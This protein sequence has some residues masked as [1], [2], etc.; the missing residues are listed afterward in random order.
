[1]FTQIW[2]RLTYIAYKRKQKVYD[3]KPFNKTAYIELL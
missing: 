1:M 3:E 2:E